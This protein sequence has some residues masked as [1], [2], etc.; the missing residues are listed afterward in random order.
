[1][2]KTKGKIIVTGGH[3]D[4]NTVPSSVK[5][6]PGGAGKPVPPD[7]KVSYYEEHLGADSLQSRKMRCLLDNREIHREL[8]RFYEQKARRTLE[9]SWKEKG[10]VATDLQLKNGIHI[11]TH[12][13]KNKLKNIDYQ[14]RCLHLDGFDMPFRPVFLVDMN[15]I[16]LNKLLPNTLTYIYQDETGRTETKTVFIDATLEKDNSTKC[17]I[18]FLEDFFFS[19]FLGYTFEEVKLISSYSFGYEERMASPVEKAIIIIEEDQ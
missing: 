1:M 14:Y 2:A 11:L 19:F 9:D 6:I 4:Q 12:E 18:P 3:V 8:V 7:T 5:Y 15:V 10:I 13:K 17:R 16:I